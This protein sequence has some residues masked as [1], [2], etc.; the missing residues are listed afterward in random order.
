M[1]AGQQSGF[2]SSTANNKNWSAGGSIQQAGSTLT[3]PSKNIFGST[4][5]ANTGGMIT[6]PT[7]SIFASVP[8]QNHQVNSQQPS[9]A[10]VPL[11][12]NLTVNQP[13]TNIFSLGQGATGG[14]SLFFGGGQQKPST[15]LL[16]SHSA[17]NQPGGFFGASGGNTGL[18]QSPS[19]SLRIDDTTRALKESQVQPQV[20]GGGLFAAQVRQ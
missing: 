20:Q 10:T 12:P 18:F 17:S 13:T 15:A 6:Q 4:A 11:A 16:G 2:F 1:S 8:N 14:T 5:V 3:T 19:A 9:G 7:N